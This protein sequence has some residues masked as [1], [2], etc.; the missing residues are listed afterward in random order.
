M[1][2]IA[3]VVALCGCASE[4]VELEERIE[5]EELPASEWKID[6]R[7]E[8]RAYSVRGLLLDRM[9]EIELICPDGTEMDLK[10]WVRV[11]NLSLLEP[12]DGEHGFVLSATQ[13]VAEEAS[14]C[15]GPCYLCPDGAWVCTHGCEYESRI[16]ARNYGNTP[17]P[18]ESGSG[19]P[20]SEPRHAAPDGPRPDGDPTPRAP[21]EPSQPPP[22][23]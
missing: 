8:T 6:L 3:L 19:Q 17:D 10:N 23:L 22:H 21:Q 9:A 7:D 11:T 20:P 5:L 15:P 18:S 4:V 1:I 13:E 12:I 14:P 16:D 2:R